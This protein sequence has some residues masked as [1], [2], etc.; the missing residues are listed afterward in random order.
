MNPSTT[1]CETVLPARPKDGRDRSNL[2]AAAA[3][4]SGVLIALSTVYLVYAAYTPLPY[5]DQW[6]NLIAGRTI[7]LDWLFALHNEHRLAVP[8]LI[9]MA[10]HALDRETNVLD[11]V[12]N[13]VLVALTGGVFARLAR[14]GGLFAKT[15]TALWSSGIILGLMFSAIQ[16]E[17][18][19]WG[20]QVQFFG[21]CTL[22]VAAFALLALTAHSRRAVA[23]VILL[24]AVATYTLS[25]G[26]LI[27]ALM[28]PL[29]IWLRRPRQQTALLA[30]AAALLT[31]SYLHGYATPEGHAG[32]A[33]ALHHLRTIAIFILAELG[34][35]PRSLVPL[36]NA[37]PA[38]L[39]GIAGAV[40]FGRWMLR[41]Y[42]E[43]AMRCPE[44]AALFAIASFAVLT[45]V[46][47]AM[48]RWTM[49]IDQAV[50]SRYATPMLLLWLPLLLAEVASLLRR[51]RSLRPIM[52][53]GLV[54][55]MMALVNQPHFIRLAAHAATMRQA[56]MPA[57]LTGVA[58]DAVI[59]RIYPSSDVV[60]AR[61]D[62]LKTD[63][64]SIFAADWAG[65][66]GRPAPAIGLSPT[67]PRCVG[68]I[69]ALDEITNE[70]HPGW[71]IVGHLDRD[72]GPA[73]RLVVV[74]ADGSVAGYGLGGFDT[75]AV[76][77]EKVPP[78]GPRDRWIGAMGAGDPA[79]V[80][81]YA[82]R[83]DLQAAC[84]FAPV[85]PAR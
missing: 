3:L 52:T 11:L 44:D 17:N 47:T 84:V 65:W 39:F 42:R 6:D 48:G 28:V 79:A 51:G 55:L 12:V 22:A 58:D 4:V 32:P 59:E 23:V 38:V 37:L 30:A 31:A 57:V 25:N 81:I 73:P 13:L 10:D 43:R 50:V 2:V 24:E 19:T 71:R 54:V 36:P 27:A 67:L 33:A 1:T 34:L 63:G 69:D 35:P 18:F 40:L 82:L 77:A 20:F 60:M 66:L 76:S 21:I 16:H 9:F 53:A 75:R 68:S 80:S 64:A 45:A 41:L 49:G 70:D 61:R 85:T 46:L 62:A 29:A 74:A 78:G 14:A 83:A 26:L 8:R 5:S 15:P 72:D 56:A 7:T